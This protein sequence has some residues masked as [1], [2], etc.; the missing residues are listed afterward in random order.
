MVGSVLLQRM[1]EEGDYDGS[2]EPVFFSTSQVG[3]P[4]PSVT[5]NVPLSDAMSV[6]ALGEM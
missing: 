3:E 2:F 6:S 5:G 4:G 1:I